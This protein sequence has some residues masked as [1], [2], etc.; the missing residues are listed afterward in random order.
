[1]NKNPN[2]RIFCDV[3]LFCSLFFFPWWASV[4]FGL[5]LVFVFDSYYELLLSAL[6]LDTLYA[7]GKLSFLMGMPFTLILSALFLISFYAK[8]HFT[9][10]S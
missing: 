8:E 9:F 5:Y 10:H 3:I 1:M 4:L 6:I 2:I 7:A